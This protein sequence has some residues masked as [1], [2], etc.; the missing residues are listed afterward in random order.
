[1]ANSSF[2]SAERKPLTR[3]KMVID[4][5]NLLTTLVWSHKQALKHFGM[6]LSVTANN[7]AYLDID[8]AGLYGYENVDDQVCTKSRTEF[9]ITKSNCPV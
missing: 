9:I 1:M 4:H 3:M 5:A 6:C 8:F 7:N 2:T